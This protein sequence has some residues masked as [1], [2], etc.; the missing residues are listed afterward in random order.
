MKKPLFI[1]L[2]LFA[3][4]Q[5]AFS[6]E[7]CLLDGPSIAC[8]QERITFLYDS[9]VTY[10]DIKIDA[11]TVISGT[12]ILALQENKTDN[13]VDIIFLSGGDAEVVVRYL[14]GNTLVALCNQNVFVFD[15]E[16]IP[17]IGMLSNFIDDQVTCGALDLT[18]EM[19]IVCPD[20][21]FYWTLNDEIIE[22]EQL[23]NS[24][25]VLQIIEAHLQVEGVGSYTF[26]HHILKKDSSCFIKDC[27]TI[28]IL[29]LEVVPSFSLDD[30]ESIFCVGASL[31][32]NNETVVEED[33]F[34]I[35][36]IEY[37]TLQWRYSGENLEFDFLLPGEYKISLQY[38]VSGDEKCISDKTS[39]IIEITDSPI[40]PITCSSNSCTDSIFTYQTP[41]DCKEYEW[42]IDE[43]LGEIISDD[44]SGVTI[45]WN[46]VDKYTE[47]RVNLYL[48]S[49]SEDACNQ[50][51]RNIAL[52][53]VSIV[54]E[55]A[56]GICD[57]GTEWYEADFIPEAVY[58]WEIEM[59][60]SISGTAPQITKLEDNRVRVTYNSYVGNLSIHVIATIASKECEVAGEFMTTS[61]FINTNNDL[62]PGDL[63][64]ATILPNIDQDVVWTLTNEDAGYIKVQT[65]SGQDD[66]FAFDL[67][68]AGTYILNVAVPELEFECGDDIPL[69]ILESPSVV[70]NGPRFI[71]PGESVTYTLEGLLDNDNVEWTIFQ[72]NMSTELTGNE[73]T[74]LWEEGGA[75]YLIKV[76]RSTEVFAGQF[77]DSESF[78]FPI[79]DIVGQLFEITG[80]EVVCYDGQGTYQIG[81]MSGTYNW[82]INPPFMGTIVEGDSAELI[83][84]QW[85]YAPDIPFATLSTSRDICDSVYTSS[86]DVYFE[87]YVPGL[88]VPDT[89]CQ[90][91]FGT[92]E[93]LG[94]ETYEIIEIFVNGILVEDQTTE[95]QHQFLD[96]GYIEVMIEVVNP[97]GCPGTVNVSKF[98]QVI[99]IL[100]VNLIALGSLQQCPK[101]SF[102]DVTFEV[103][104]QDPIGYY[105]WFLDG[106]IIK[107][108]FGEP[109]L[110]FFIVTRDMIL[111]GAKDFNVVVSY[112]EFCDG[113]AGQGLDYDCIEIRCICIEDVIGMVDYITPLECNL[114]NFGGSLDFSTVIDPYWRIA[115]NDTIIEIP[116]NNEGDLIQDSFYFEEGT[117]QAQVAL[118][119]TCEGLNI[120]NGEI[121]DT[122]LC[123]IFIDQL[124]VP[125]Y[126]PDFVR[127]YFCN[128][129][130]TYDIIFTEKNLRNSNPPFNSTVSW[131]INGIAYEGIS[132]LVED[133][134]GGSPLIIEMTQCSLDGSYCCS[135]EYETT[136]R[137]KFSPNIILPNGSCENDLWLFTLDVNQSAIQSVLWDFGDESGSTLLLT[138]KG[139]L[140]TL[141]HNISVVVTD[142]VGCV[143][144]AETTVK[145]FPNELDGQI[146]FES[147]P[148]APNATLTYIENSESTIFNY[149]WDILNSPDTSSIEVSVSGDYSV[150]VTDI[151][152]CTSIANVSDIKVNES[153]TGGMRFDP[154][155][156]GQ[157]SASVFA[158]S[159]YS[160]EW[161][162]NGNFT[163][164]SNNILL[165]FS[166]EYEIKVISISN[167]TN[168]V[169]DSI[170]ENII[171]HPLP[172][173]PIIL[174]DKIYCDPFIIE[175]S[176]ANYPSVSWNSNV[177]LSQDASSILVS[178]NGTYQASVVDDNGCRKSASRVINEKEVPFEQLIDECIHAC[179]EDLD[180][181]M[182]TIPGIDQFASNWTWITVDTFGIEYEVAASSGFIEPLTI[183][184]DMYEYVQLQITQNDGCVL[185]SER[186]PLDIEICRQPEPPVEIICE[187]ID[188]DHASCGQSIYKCLVSE[189]NGGPKLYFEGNVILPMDAV[190]C[191]EDS[192]TVSLNNGEIVITD[193][194]FEA[195]DGKIM[196]FYSANII[197]TD[198]EDY[199]ENGTIIKFDF[200]NEEGELAYCYEYALPYRTCNKDF[201]CLIDFHGV[202]SGGNMTINIDYCLNL[203]EVVQDDC[204][205]SSYEIRA[206]L[207]G[208]VAVKTIFTYTLEDDFDDLHCI[209]VPVS[210]DDFFGGEYQCIELMIVGD[211]PGISCSEFQCGIFGSSNL[212]SNSG[213]AE[214][215]EVNKDL[216]QNDLVKIH[217]EVR[218][219]EFIIYPNPSSGFLTFELEKKQ[220]GGLI[221]LK[222]VQGKIIR[223][224]QIKNDDK[225]SLD[226]SNEISG[227]YFATWIREGRFVQTK[228]LIL[229][230]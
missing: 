93:I 41:I 199:K 70:L 78:T 57:K 137:Q 223:N 228:K 143:A 30:D 66:F 207:S 29:E 104:F 202:S 174:E 157:A 18:F 59:I 43:S 45:L 82:E 40:I 44:T 102:E 36:E 208:D 145:S 170:I 171:I 42:E 110:Y 161:Y 162:V 1:F 63:F 21:P 197:I 67:N 120:V 47:T 195:T 69:T 172:D 80:P 94:L 60:D 34:Y 122:T 98:V 61:L 23:T 108:G 153:F 123:E 217:E 3:I 196:A 194:V 216:S 191:S 229:I 22:L 187:P 11:F 24:G 149:E 178:Q 75:P 150:T 159:D 186:I 144:T 117:L 139:F 71:C 151:N 46:E 180:S 35:W 4:I 84:I 2:I 168:E 54:I 55:G 14:N 96:T 65:L 210:Y 17:A 185:R 90:F 225:I 81:E 167:S 86:I 203:S 12:Q 48:G 95:D 97:N 113:S 10:T 87:P 49:C 32:F 91:D 125:L 183:T 176:A 166:G 111:N 16:P 201:D 37:D 140:D 68:E 146:Q 115:M 31:Q 27:I 189:E 218:N 163:S 38:Y 8:N 148:C 19:F 219:N 52:F 127:E 53:P 215:V 204:T 184:S 26:C 134:E 147:D 79:N 77:C 130:L 142:K 169:C 190:L 188:S 89:I 128:E 85:H 182:I 192:L 154:E 64:K 158:N 132:I 73:I 193:L 6:Q 173:S 155:N 221:I 205:L 118:R 114:V 222:N 179:R 51:F 209:S 107:E 100:D 230:K 200:C 198:P 226:L 76:S 92:I 141:A 126:Y 5:S 88:S 9:D 7:K 138:E 212:V 214:A 50:T 119:G 116:I 15:E 175:L 56:R 131:I 99:P 58:V 165:S 206:I 112:P 224:I 101:D 156:C 105:V 152:G 74:V 133:Q 72:N 121:I 164:S 25:E 220:E 83:T 39:M 103:D 177:L 135:N 124:T 227:L 160:Y 62:C 109:D 13:S 129:D 106:E 33:V 181:L 213:D 20:C 211:C 136:V 28:D